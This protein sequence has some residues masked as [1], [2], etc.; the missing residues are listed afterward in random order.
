[1]AAVT[2]DHLIIRNPDLVAAD[3]DGDTVMMSIERGEYYGISGVGSR[4][5]ELLERPTT[6]AAI[7]EIIHAE[8]EVDEETCLTDARKFILELMDNGLVVSA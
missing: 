1:M 4:I 5:W 8:F 3:M 7:C 2:L 6:L